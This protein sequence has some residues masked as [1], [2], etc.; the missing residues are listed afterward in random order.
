MAL[1]R[2][3]SVAFRR[4]RSESYR[5]PPVTL[6]ADWPPELSVSIRVALGVF[7]LRWEYSRSVGSL[8]SGAGGRKMGPEAR[9]R[10]GVGR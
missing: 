2:R 10:E 3:T 1:V 5:H 9:G 7:A 6:H 8:A 4:S